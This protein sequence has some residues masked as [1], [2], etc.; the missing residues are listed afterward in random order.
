MTKG[1][2]GGSQ[3]AKIE[4]IKWIVALRIEGN[5][6]FLKHMHTYPRTCHWCKN[7]KTN[8]FRRECNIPL[9]S[10]AP[11]RH[12]THL[13]NQGKSK[14]KREKSNL[15]FCHE[16]RMWHRGVSSLCWYIVPCCSFW[17]SFIRL[18]VGKKFIWNWTIL[19]RMWDYKRHTVWD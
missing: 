18:Y 11:T 10:A 19:G 9:A 17:L 4:L 15:S 13:N 8:V 1:A 12:Q 3:M 14:K 5:H 16:A 6:G 2:V 7:I